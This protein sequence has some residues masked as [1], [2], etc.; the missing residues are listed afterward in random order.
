MENIEQLLYG[1][2]KKAGSK[3]RYAL[4]NLFDY[5]NASQDAYTYVFNPTSESA[6]ICYEGLLTI[7]YKLTGNIAGYCIVEAK[8]RTEDYKELIFEQKK[9]NNL[10]KE[11]RNKDKY[12]KTNWSEHTV[13]ILYI[14]FL[15]SKTIIFD[16]LTLSENNLLPKL[17]KKTMNKITV[18]STEDKEDKMVYLLDVEELGVKSKYV[19]DNSVYAKDLLRQSI[20][21]LIQVNEIEK[22]TYSIF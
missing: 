16:V 12:F 17:T 9:F 21:N 18:A 20:D 10:K 15:P 2:Y 8:V 14:N 6:K 13:G 22:T 1:K 19:F 3:E 11:K 4:E 7:K 5:M